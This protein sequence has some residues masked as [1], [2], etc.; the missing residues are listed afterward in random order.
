MSELT[1]SL[2]NLPAISNLLVLGTAKT[3]DHGEDGD[4][5]G[6]AKRGRETKKNKRTKQ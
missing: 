2:V 6:E 3:T 5:D 4:G 1:C